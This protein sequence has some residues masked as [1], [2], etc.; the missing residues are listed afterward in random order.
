MA[1]NIFQPWMMM[2]KKMGRKKKKNRGGMKMKEKQ[3][4]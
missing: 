1:H 4:P 3:A 2:K